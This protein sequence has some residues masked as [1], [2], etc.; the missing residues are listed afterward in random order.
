MSIVSE[1]RLGLTDLDI[2]SACAKVPD[3]SANAAPGRGE[4]FRE[5][6]GGGHLFQR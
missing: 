2:Y 4:K 6:V 1:K 3:L 5:P